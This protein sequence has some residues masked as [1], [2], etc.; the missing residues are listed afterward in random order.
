[1]CFLGTSIPLLGSRDRGTKGT[2]Q[3]G[4]NEGQVD[5][6]L[7][8]GVMKVMMETGTVGKGRRAGPLKSCGREREGQG[9]VLGRHSPPSRGS[10]MMR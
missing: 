9:D 8:C 2:S 10:R 6:K 3:G 4:R 1:M 7:K 5:R